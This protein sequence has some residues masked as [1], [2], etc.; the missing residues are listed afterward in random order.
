MST[1]STINELPESQSHVLP[2]EVF[3]MDSTTE[4]MVDSTMNISE[5]VS[6]P[7]EATCVAVIIGCNAPTSKSILI[8]PS[9]TS[10]SSAP[11]PRSHPPSRASST[12][13][14]TLPTLADGIETVTPAMTRPSSFDSSNEYSVCEQSQQGEELSQEQRLNVKFAPLPDVGPRK[15][16]SMP[17]G[18]A[19]RSRMVRRRK[20]QG[21]EPGAQPRVVATPMWTDEEMEVQRHR[22][23]KAWEKER[24]KRN[25]YPELDENGEP[26][27]DPITAL[28]KLVKV[29]GKQL[30]NKIGGREGKDEK[31]KVK[32]RVEK[33]NDA[34][35]GKQ[36]GSGEARC[37]TSS[38]SPSQTD[39]TSSE[40]RT[41]VP[42][43]IDKE[44]DKSWEE[45]RRKEL[46]R[47]QPDDGAIARKRSLWRRTRTAS[48]IEG[49][50]SSTSIT[51]SS[52]AGKNFSFPGRK[53]DASK[54]EIQPEVLTGL[55]R[56]L[57]F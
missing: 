5:Y 44:K 3:S 31:V 55:R 30:W 27:E 36:R 6:S 16:R 48:K 49:D 15:K 38:V 57:S 37:S 11:F 8:S 40:E 32:A 47:T 42:D 35:S 7:A 24:E 10:S 13:S 50:S 56:S 53:S 20:T 25:Y 4:T 43:G 46:Q 28:G 2:L 29:A 51:K 12:T 33:E 18:V 23:A 19:A 9:R 22:L 41:P 21:G 14:T 34:P 52:S 17:L 45:I 54:G 26:I 1:Q 39:R